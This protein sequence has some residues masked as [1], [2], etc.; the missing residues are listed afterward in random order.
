MVR[1]AKALRSSES[2]LGDAGAAEEKYHIYVYGKVQSPDFQMYKVAAEHLA[3][4][5][6]GIECTVEGCFETQ[7]EQQLRYL[8]SKYGG[9]FVQAKPAYAIVFVE[10]ADS[11]LYFANESRFLEWAF[12]RFKYEDK[13]RSVFYKRVGNKALKAVKDSSGRSYCALGFTA[14][15][16]PQETVQLELFDEECP[17]TCRNF[18]DL[19][20]HE[21]FDGHPLHRVKAGSWIQGGDLVDGSGL[22]SE[23]MGGEP[24]RH[25]SFQ[26]PHDRG[27]LL[28]MANCGKDTNGSQFYITTRELPFL[29]GKFVVFGRVISGMRTVLKISKSATRNER[30]VKDVKISAQKD[31]TVLGAIQ[32]KF[33]KDMEE[34]ATKL[35][36]MQRGKLARAKVQEKKAAN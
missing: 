24:L 19:L 28:G 29:N 35:Q 10:T 17:I 21:K 12:K 33:D 30:P 3:K 31:F 16:D 32:K 4:E 15:D 6:R 20:S 25:E 27:G 36:S 13:T 5:R 14:G 11:V 22:H 9:S 23:A 26:I 1:S 7:Y 2:D 34:A 8:I 18:L